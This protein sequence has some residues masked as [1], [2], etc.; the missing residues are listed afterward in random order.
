MDC[1]LHKGHAK[2]AILMTR[3]QLLSNLSPPSESSQLF[4]FVQVGLT[5]IAS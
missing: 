4:L 5:N 2:S 3:S 1:E